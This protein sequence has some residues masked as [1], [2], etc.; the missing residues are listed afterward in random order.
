MDRVIKA[1]QQMEERMNGKFKNL[2]GKI[3]LVTNQLNRME[4][5]LNIVA[6]TASDNTMSIL[7]RIDVNTSSSKQD[8]D[9]LAKQVGKHEMYF[10]RL[11]KS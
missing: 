8:V 1:I 5:S 7:K 4:D 2:E 3:K 9:Y 10:N 6:Q 11:N